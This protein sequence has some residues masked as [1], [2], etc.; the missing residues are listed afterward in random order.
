MHSYTCVSMEF[1][2]RVS[3][4]FISITSN[5][6]DNPTIFAMAINNDDIL[7]THMTQLVRYTY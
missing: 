1:L 4:A 3:D 6:Q 7:Y 2:L 5:P